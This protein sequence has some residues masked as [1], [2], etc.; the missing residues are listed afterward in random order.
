MAE[1]FFKDDGFIP[2]SQFSVIL[3]RKMVNLRG[4]NATEAEVALKKRGLKTGWNLEWLWPVFKRPHYHSTTHEALVVYQGLATLRL[5]GHRLGKLVKV[6]QGDAIIIPAGV[7]HQ[8]VERTENFQ[9][10]GFYPIG[11][12]QWDMRFCSKKEREIA[13]PKLALLGEPPSFKL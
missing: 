7:A 5:G 12:Q 6:N 4:V 3:T 11:A 1:L 13:L 10:F 2:N 8:A 9:V